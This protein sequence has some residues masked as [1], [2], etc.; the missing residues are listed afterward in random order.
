MGI[1]QRRERERGEVRSLIMETARR[2]FAAEGYSAV[3]MRRIA[4]AIEYSATAIYV[5]FK[6]KESLIRE[7]CT[8]DFGRLAGEFVRLAKVKDPIERI[9]QAGHLYIQFAVKHPNHYRLMFMT[10]MDA[11]PVEDDHEC[12]KGNPEQ[13]A[14]AFLL[15]S[16]QEALRARR[17]ASRYKDPRVL[18]QTFW[19]AVHGVAS[20]EITM[21]RDK[22]IDWASLDDRATAAIEATLRGL[23]RSGAASARRTK[24]KAGGK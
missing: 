14:Y 10:P 4:D 11:V 7:L 8:E 19:A 12:G 3:S 21:G 2:L 17:F 9:R 22:W 13:D 18:A 6:D 15:Q 1:L 20:L 24:T 5:H 16:V 23:D